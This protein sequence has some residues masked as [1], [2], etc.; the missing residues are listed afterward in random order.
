[1]KLKCLLSFLIFLFFISVNAQ[2]KNIAVTPAGIIITPDNVII[3]PE[4]PLPVKD[5]AL[6]HGV[7]NNCRTKIIKE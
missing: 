5:S 2:N 6:R 1:M 4:N 3:T 7:S